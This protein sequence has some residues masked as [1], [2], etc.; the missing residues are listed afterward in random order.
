[1]IGGSDGSLRYEITAYSWAKN[2]EITL[3]YGEGVAIDN[4]YKIEIRDSY[5]HTAADPTP[6]G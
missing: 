2:V 3:W 1:M 5:I 4:S 6:G